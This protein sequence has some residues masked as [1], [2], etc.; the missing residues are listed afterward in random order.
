MY[1]RD[2]SGDDP[3]PEEVF[4]ESV[5]VDQQEEMQ[6]SA[7]QCNAC[8]R[9]FDEVHYVSAWES[10]I[11]GHEYEVRAKWEATATE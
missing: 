3:I 6:A 11:L 1:W 8:A 5:L 7:S 10:F 9:Y 4:S 2:I